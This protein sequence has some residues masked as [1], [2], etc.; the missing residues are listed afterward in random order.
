MLYLIG[1]GLGQ[2]D[3]ITVEGLEIVKSADLVYLEHHTSTLSHGKETLEKFYGREIILAKGEIIEQ[4]SEEFIEPAKEKNIALLVIGD[5]FD[6][7]THYKLVLNAVKMNVAYKIVHNASIELAVGCCGLQLY[8]FGGTVSIKFWDNTSKP[9]SFFDKIEANL[10]LGKHTL[11]LLDMKLK[12]QSI[13]NLTKGNNIFEPP[14]YMSVACAASQLL[15]IAKNRGD[16]SVL[17]KDTTCVGLARLGSDSQ[18]I[19]AGS[20]FEVGHRDLGAPLHTLIVCGKLHDLESEFL[21]LFM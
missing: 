15:E 7:T 17:T 16:K 6:D 21:Q 20:L 13:E 18:K 5:P 1:L 8:N 10:K 11:C 14:R 9:E 3:D 2:P 4:K 19:V 12:E